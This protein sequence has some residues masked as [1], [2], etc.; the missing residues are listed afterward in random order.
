LP[1]SKN[2]CRLRHFSLDSIL[3]DLKAK[4]NRQERIFAVYGNN[5][6]LI[7]PEEGTQDEIIRA[8]VNSAIEYGKY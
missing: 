6:F 5:S 2:F 8:M 1:P 7:S 4:S 3:S